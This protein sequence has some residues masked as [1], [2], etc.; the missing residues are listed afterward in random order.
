MRRKQWVGLRVQACR[1]RRWGRQSA[2]TSWLIMFRQC[3]D[4]GDDDDDDVGDDDGDD[5]DVNK[6]SDCPVEWVQGQRGSWAVMEDSQ[7]RT[8]AQWAVCTWQWAVQCWEDGTVCNEQC[9]YDGTRCTV[10]TF[11]KPQTLRFL[12]HY[13]ITI[14]RMYALQC[15]VIWYNPVILHCIVGF[16]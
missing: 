13:R 9:C 8:L 15:S 3:D 10:Q 14:A 5:D 6:W 7:G 11:L 12:P 16:S 4:D 2:R 1:C